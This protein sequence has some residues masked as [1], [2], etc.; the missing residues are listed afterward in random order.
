MTDRKML[1]VEY[2]GD[3]YYIE[4]KALTKHI[5]GNLDDLRQHVLTTTDI[6]NKK[7]AVVVVLALTAVSIVASLAFAGA[8]FWAFV[9]AF[10]ALADVK[11]VLKF[12]EKSSK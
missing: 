9:V 12:L 11:P 5:E 8:T 4:E 3:G 2:D 6:S 10:I 7:F 1:P